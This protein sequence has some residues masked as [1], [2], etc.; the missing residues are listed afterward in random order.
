MISEQLIALCDRV[1]KMYC[2]LPTGVVMS[3]P[4]HADAR[5]MLHLILDSLGHCD[6]GGYLAV[7]RHY[8]RGGTGAGTDWNIGLMLYRSDAAFKA[9]YHRI[10]TIIQHERRA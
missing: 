10:I 4:D 1:C 2:D 7:A 8:G 5:G 3:E 9:M 6:K